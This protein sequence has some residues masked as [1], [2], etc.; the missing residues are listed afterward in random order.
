MTI[1][2]PAAS[3]RRSSAPGHQARRQVRDRRLLPRQV[4]IDLSAIVRNDISIHTSPRRGRQQRQAGGRARRAG[5]IRGAEMVTHHF[6]LKDIAEALRWLPRRDGD[7]VKV[8]VQP[9]CTALRKLVGCLRVLAAA[10]GDVSRDQVA[11]AGNGHAGRRTPAPRSQNER[12]GGHGLGGR[13]TGSARRHEW[14]V[15]RGRRRRSVGRLASVSASRQCSAA[16][17][18]RD[19]AGPASHRAVPSLMVR[20]DR[21]DD[22]R[23]S[24]CRWSSGYA[25]AAV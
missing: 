21:T 14:A 8:V 19:A 10:G 7:P 20:A 13:R 2:A 23:L 1:G 16:G 25:R 24:L 6:P 18:S 11:V 9:S 3:T 12:R 17:C 15:P 5:K 22:V 4:T